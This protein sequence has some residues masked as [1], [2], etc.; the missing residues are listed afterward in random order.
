MQAAARLDRPPL[1]LLW[2]ASLSEPRP[3][4]ARTRA[5]RRQ[6]AMTNPPARPT[7]VDSTPA[8]PALTA[9]DAQ[10]VST[11]IQVELAR[12]TREMYAGAWRQWEP[13]AGGEASTRYPQ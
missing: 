10:R 11:A 3:P 4:F 7:V 5:R 6:W 2:G 9:S 8:R 13:G 1:T 12:S